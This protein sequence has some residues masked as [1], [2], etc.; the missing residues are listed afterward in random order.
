MPPSSH[1]KCTGQ[2]RAIRHASSD[3]A[4]A[5]RDTSCADDKSDRIVALFE[6]RE[7]VPVLLALRRIGRETRT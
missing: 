6:R 2:T 7:V 1:V 4:A 3:A 5:E